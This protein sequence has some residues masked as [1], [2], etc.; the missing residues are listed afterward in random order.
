MITYYTEKVVFL[1][2]LK[3][4]WDPPKL[5]CSIN[6]EFDEKWI[7][8]DLAQYPQITSDTLTI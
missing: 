4:Q 5:F 2:W 1:C 6:S 3:K 8:D 7:L